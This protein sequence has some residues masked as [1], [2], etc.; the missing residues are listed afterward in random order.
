[1][2]TLN[3]FAALIFTATTAVSSHASQFEELFALA[4]ANDPSYLAAQ[5]ML[6]SKLQIIPH[7][8]SASSSA[9]SA[10]MSIKI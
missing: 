9:L 1:M 5:H 4:Q 2:A 10:A 7:A 6:E 8:K 3:R